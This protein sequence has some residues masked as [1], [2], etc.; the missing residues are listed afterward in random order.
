MSWLRD[1]LFIER[2]WRSVKFEEVY[3]HAYESVS[4]AKAGI[5]RHMRF[6]NSRGPHTAL[7]DQTQDRA[8]FSSLPA[9]LRQNPAGTLLSQ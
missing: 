2:F 4:Q 6:Y 3:L 1:N 5:D 9:T 8:H 7:A